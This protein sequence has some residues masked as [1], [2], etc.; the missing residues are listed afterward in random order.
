V[1]L[2]QLA[3]QDPLINVRQND[4]AGE[5]SVWLYGE[6]QKEVI[7]TTLA[8]D[9]GIDV[10]FHETT[11]ICIE[12]PVGSG[13]DLELLQ[14]DA[15]PYSATLGLRIAPAA[16][17]SGVTFRVD[18]DPRTVPIHIYKTADNFVAHM[19][20][21]IES[22]LQEGLFG[23]QVT[24]CTV[25][26]THCGYYASDG[27]TKPS[28]GTTRTIAADFRKL[29]PFVLKRALRQAKTVVCEPIIRASIEAPSDTLGAVLAAVARLGGAIERSS[30]RGDIAVIET[31]MP[32]ARLQ[33]LQRRLPGLS[34]G[35][36][37]LESSFGGYA[38][39]SGRPPI[40]RRG[41]APR[42]PA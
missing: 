35:E 16:T 28:G 3:E 21:Y 5:M 1:A 12:R 14:W 7:G 29:T 6:V 24:D 4:A 32:A 34:G 40:R 38:P 39:V 22:T 37:V 9:F 15:N 41:R 17:G 19:Q 25:T 10:S 42:D 20:Q 13:S 33:E 8:T 30:Q 2:D 23:W 31:V 18:V 36:A 26:M 11:A 27:P